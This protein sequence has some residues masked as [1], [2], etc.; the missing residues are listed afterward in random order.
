VNR[1][2][3]CPDRRFAFVRKN[4]PLLLELANHIDSNLLLCIRLLE[5][6]ALILGLD[7]DTNGRLKNIG[8]LVVKE[9]TRIRLFKGTNRLLKDCKIG[10]IGEHLL[11]LRGKGVE[12]VKK[13]LEEDAAGCHCVY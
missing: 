5:E 13:G 2:D 6:E 3:L 8:L 7:L 9:E 4:R 11:E 10:V 12:L 1:L